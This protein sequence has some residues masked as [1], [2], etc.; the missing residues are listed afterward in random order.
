MKNKPFSIG[1]TVIQPGERVTLGLPT[2]ELYT[3]ASLH[4]PIHIIHGK[5]TGPTLLICAAIHGDEMNGTAIIHRLLKL[6]LLKSLQGTLIAAPVIN[7]FGL[8]THAR[9]LPDRRDLDASFPGS[10]TGSF[11]AR[12]AHYFKKEI[13][14]K[15][16]HCIDIHSGEPHQY[17]FPQIHTNLDLPETKS[18]A[19]AFQAPVTNHT[20]SER[21]LLWQNRETPPIPTL[22]YEAGEPLRLDEWGIRIGLKGIIRVMRHLN[23]LSLKSKMQKPFSP[24]I[25]REKHWLRAPGSGLCEQYKKM[26]SYVRKGEVLAEIYDPF[27]TTQHFRL[28]APDDGLIIAKNT[29]PLVNEGDPIV[30]IAQTQEKFERLNWDQCESPIENL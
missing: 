4:M 29:L 8:I 24:M 22:M 14:G 25:V 19:S 3:Y 12:L 18:L 11:A 9:N 2:P 20:E 26:G 17:W 13:L 1:N 6:G 27:G 30:H 10:E 5:R 15:I 23:M 21:G 7:I 16:T 28:C